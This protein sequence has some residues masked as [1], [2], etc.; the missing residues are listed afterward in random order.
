MSSKMNGFAQGT[1]LKVAYSMLALTSC[2]VLAQTG[3][4]FYKAKL[5]SASGC[6]VYIA[7]ACFATVCALYIALSPYMQR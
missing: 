6:L 3:V 2:V 1:V 4:G 5:L 7:F